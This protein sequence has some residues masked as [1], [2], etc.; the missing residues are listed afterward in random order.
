MR[1]A[2]YACLAYA[3]LHC[4]RCSFV[5]SQG[6]QIAMFGNKRWP[7]QPRLGSRE[8]HTH[9]RFV[10]SFKKCPNWNVA[11]T[12]CHRVHEG[13]RPC[14]R[15]NLGNNQSVYATIDYLLSHD[16]Q[17]HKRNHRASLLTV[18]RV[19]RSMSLSFFSLLEQK[20]SEAPLMC[21][22]KRRA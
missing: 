11:Q 2:L 14:H 21:A 15:K 13:K 3:A 16:G 8:L 10:S 12:A 4:R 20:R 22:T 9:K 19:R 7:E 5:V 6:L 1:S 17:K 18:L